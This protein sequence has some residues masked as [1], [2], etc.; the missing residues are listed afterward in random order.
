MSVRATSL[1]VQFA[2]KP[3]TSETQPPVVPAAGPCGSAGSAFRPDDGLGACAFLAVDTEGLAREDLRGKSLFFIR[4]GNDDNDRTEFFAPL[5]ALLPGKLLESLA[6]T[7]AVANRATSANASV[8]ASRPLV[9]AQAI[10]EIGLEG[11]LFM[12]LVLSLRKDSLGDCHEP[13]AFPKQA[14]R[15]ML[16][17]LAALEMQPSLC[18][19]CAASDKQRQRRPIQN[20]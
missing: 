6:R 14:W 20:E 10:L 7:P 3:D 8:S 1:A 12:I 4:E 16:F 13:K 19:T 9:Q 11:L 15:G 2:L 5:A 18:V 17:G